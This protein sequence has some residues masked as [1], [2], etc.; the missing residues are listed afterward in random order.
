MVYA[1]CRKLYEGN[2]DMYNKSLNTHVFLP[3]DLSCFAKVFRFLA[4]LC[5]R[6]YVRDRFCKPD[7]THED[8]YEEDDKEENIKKLIQSGAPH[9]CILS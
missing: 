3:S 9:M 6:A 1:H 8:K 7:K 2:I 5:G 4:M